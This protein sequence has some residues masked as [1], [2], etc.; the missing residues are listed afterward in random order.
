MSPIEQVHDRLVFGR[1]V[2]MLAQHLAELLPPSAC[3]LDVGC[4]DG[5]LD[6]LILQ[7]R[8]DIRIRGVDV[9]VRGRTHVPVE[10]FDGQTL[11][12]SEGE[13][14]VVLF[15]DVLHHTEDPAMLLREGARVAGEAVL[16]KDH[17]AD[18]FLASP[19]LRFMDHVGNARYGVALPYNYWTERRWRDTFRNLGLTVTAWKKDLGL[20][21]WPA[22]WVFG[23]SL[24]F[25]ARLEKAGSPVHV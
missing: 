11:P 10:K 17:T 3:V 18:G 9:L 5:L 6:H 12:F 2:R 19:T 4:G 7:Q 8:P 20:Y 24:H 23:R 25:V 1:R 22:D 15:V 16:L 14:D 21:P 13:F